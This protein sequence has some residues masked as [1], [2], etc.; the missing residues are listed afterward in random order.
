MRWK[1]LPGT[2]G[3]PRRTATMAHDTREEAFLTPLTR[4]M[5]SST[6]KRGVLGAKHITCAGWVMKPVIGQLLKLNDDKK[7]TQTIESHQMRSEIC[8][9]P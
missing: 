7:M 1:G 2:F 3:P 8:F 9:E 4:T 6:T 5:G